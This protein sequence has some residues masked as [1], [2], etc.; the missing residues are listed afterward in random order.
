MGISLLSPMPQYKSVNKK[1]NKSKTKLL[2]YVFTSKQKPREKYHLCC[3]TPKK[4]VR[5]RVAEEYC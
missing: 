5:S 1:I 4:V 2:V 3:E